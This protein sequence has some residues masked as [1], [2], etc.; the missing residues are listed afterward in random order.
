MRTVKLGILGILV[1]VI[2]LWGNL[3]W[4]FSPARIVE[5]S[6][7][8]VDTVFVSSSS[9]LSNKL[10]IG[11]RAYAQ[12]VNITQEQADKRYKKKTDFNE[13]LNTTLR[14]IYLV[15][16]PLLVIAG[17]A[18]DNTL[19]YGKIFHLDAILWQIWDVM[20]NFANFTLIFV[21]FY[22]ILKGI[23]ESNTKNIQ[24]V[25]K[26]L[27]IAGVLIQASWFWMGAVIDLSTIAVH[28]L[29]SLPGISD[30]VSGGNTQD[31]VLSRPIVSPTIVSY[32][33][34]ARSFKWYRYGNRA[35]IAECYTKK[36]SNNFY[37]VWRKLFSP[38]GFVSDQGI[39]I[40]S[41]TW[42]AGGI[43]SDGHEIY[44]YNPT[45]E[46]TLLDS[47]E[48]VAIS[49]PMSKSSAYDAFITNDIFSWANIKNEHIE[50]GVAIAMYATN[51]SG[52]N[53]CGDTGDA[54]CGPIAYTG[55]FYVGSGINW[56]TLKKVLNNST[57]YVWS[58]VTLYAQLLWFSDMHHLTTGNNTLT[59]NVINWIF[60]VI[61]ALLLLIPLLSMAVVL[62][63]R[64]G[65]LW[66]AIIFMP[67]LIIKWVFFAKDEKMGWEWIGKTF[68]IWNLVSLIFS[69]VVMVF[70]LAVSLV[71][72]TAINQI[73]K[74]T[75]DA[76]VMGVNVTH[77]NESIC[78]SK[79][80]VLGLVEI[81]D[82]W[83]FGVGKDLFSVILM[84][85][86][87]I[88]VMW[89][90]LFAAIKTNSLWE[91]VGGAI[92][93]LSHKV[94]TTMP[95]IPTG[96][97]KIWFNTFN[98]EILK[99]GV[100]DKVF[101]QQEREEQKK[102][103]RLFPSLYGE[104]SKEQVGD[105]MRAQMARDIGKGMNLD[106]FYTTYKDDLDKKWYINRKD[107][108]EFYNSL[109]KESTENFSHEN[110]SSYVLEQL[111][112]GKDMTSIM[113]DTK[114]AHTLGKNNGFEIW[115]YD[116][117]EKNIEKT[118]IKDLAIE[119]VDVSDGI[120][121]DNASM[122]LDKV[123]AKLKAVDED[124]KVLE[125][126]PEKAEELKEKRNKHTKLEQ[127][128]EYLNKQNETTS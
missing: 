111:S 59:G 91:M 73:T 33:N 85:F 4:F 106:T 51:F 7:S 97:G 47:S 48:F 43:C 13:L 18:I 25:V 83:Y 10:F 104:P 93:G 6:V 27:L 40:P 12:G 96:K 57:S 64:V 107:V 80:D 42:F 109:T 61:F 98:K 108:E 23:I 94:L 2:T 84:N 112:S 36:S 127:L 16:W 69:P 44:R 125:K 123:N 14:I 92:Q 62:I 19:V 11:N 95:I 20:R 54:Q 118:I 105:K 5:S 82:Q 88:W 56:M 46:N 126:D 58:F 116:A 28:G 65:V 76:S 128:Q 121:K 86:F 35:P 17:L 30:M 45:P 60:K 102:L 37:I 49:G 72:M 31:S 124:I 89:F 75:I 3:W 55:A 71:F 8:N 22:H 32:D 90:L 9:S 87:A 120:T 15:L 53:F 113:H 74:T 103:Q 119:D 78:V 114:V 1:F 117:F 122:I 66:L 63:L 52:M 34:N 101:Q 99:W 70:A 26:N 67:F 29:G 79:I 110:L 24:N 38:S 41:Y 115:Q 68:S 77:P 39:T 81:C 21:A 100:A 50:N